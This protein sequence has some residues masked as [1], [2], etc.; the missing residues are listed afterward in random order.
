MADL[1]NASSFC[2]TGIFCTLQQ[3]KPKTWPACWGCANSVPPTHSSGGGHQPPRP[4]T[5]MRQRCVVAAREGFFEYRV[6]RPVG[7]RKRQAR[8]GGAG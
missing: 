8:R 3:A 4:S 2:Q 6:A 5:P 1:G 7:V